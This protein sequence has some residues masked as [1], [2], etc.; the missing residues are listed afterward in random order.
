ME[1]GAAQEP[2]ARRAW[3]GAHVALERRKGDESRPREAKSR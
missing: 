2:Q 3:S 1:D